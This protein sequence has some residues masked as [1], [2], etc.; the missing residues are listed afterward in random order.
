MLFQLLKDKCDDGKMNVIIYN[1]QS[2]KK[3]EHELSDMSDAMENKDEDEVD[4]SD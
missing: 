1:L 4:S 2:N 3:F